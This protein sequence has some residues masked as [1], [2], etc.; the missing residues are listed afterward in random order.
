[1][2]VRRRQKLCPPGLDRSHLGHG[3][4]L[5]TVAIS[6]RVIGQSFK[7]ALGTGVQVSPE[8]GGATGDEIVDDA[9]LNRDT[10]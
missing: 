2:K 9:L 3:L 1:M 6:A 4:A 7:V 5:G 8:L 10:E